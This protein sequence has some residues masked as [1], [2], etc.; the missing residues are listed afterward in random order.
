MEI[1]LH[2]E[3]TKK[4][5]CG[6]PHSVWYWI[7]KIMIVLAILFLVAIISLAAGVKMNKF[8]DKLGKDGR[9]GMIKYSQ[10][11]G[12]GKVMMLGKNF[13]KTCESDGLAL[14][15]LFGVVSKVEGNKI[16]IVDNSVTLKTVLS[17]AETTIT[18][19]SGEVG[20]G[21][22]KQGQNI[23][24]FGSLNKDK[25]LEAKTIAIQ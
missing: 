7:I 10:E 21:F 11:L 12:T 25:M 17:S 18:T 3:G 13:Y 15:R 19:T 22:L 6:G 14:T 9:F 24:I 16:F 20:I 2:E 1:K 4:C 23:V 5:C 8:G